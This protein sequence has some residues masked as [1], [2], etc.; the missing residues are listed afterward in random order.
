ME[1]TMDN[2]GEYIKRERERKGITI[3][4]ASRVTKIGK[5]FLQA[6]EE[7]NFE[8]QLPVFMK[9]FLKS[10]AGYLGLDVNDILERYNSILTDKKGEKVEEERIEPVREQKRYIVP[11]LIA[12]SLLVL[13]VAVLFSI[14]TPDSTKTEVIEPATMANRAV[15]PILTTPQARLFPSLTTQALPQD[16]PVAMT[17]QTTE[18]PQAKTLLVTAKE[19]TWLRITVD[20]G[21]PTE[22]LMKEGESRTWI[23]ERKF[24]ILSGNAGS[25][26]LTLDGDPLGSLGEPGKVALKVLP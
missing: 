22:V 18:R 12:L 5:V 24:T 8:I 17:N 23:A 15:H 14:K 11:G 10:Y 2:L 21:N 20:D 13:A 3:E 9:G 25:I 26:D 4:E 6:I 7:G 1:A 19:L 16:K